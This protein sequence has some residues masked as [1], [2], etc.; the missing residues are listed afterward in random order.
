MV[1]ALPL[2]VVTAIYSSRSPVPLALLIRD[3]VYRLGTLRCRCSWQWG[4]ELLHSWP[5]RFSRQL[6]VPH[7]APRLAF[8]AHGKVRSPFDMWSAM[9]FCCNNHLALDDTRVKLSSTQ[10]ERT[11]CECPENSWYAAHSVGV[12]ELK[13]GGSRYHFPEY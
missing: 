4:L 9:A 11:F 13:S 5:L 2:T 12:S 1:P 3:C 6:F 8:S 10:S 7:I